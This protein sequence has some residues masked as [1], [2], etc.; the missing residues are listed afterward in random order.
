M[1][2]L[3]FTKKMLTLMFYEEMTTLEKFAIFHELPLLV[4]FLQCLNFLNIKAW[5]WNFLTITTWKL[6]FMPIFWYHFCFTTYLTFW[7]KEK[8]KLENRSAL[9]RILAVFWL[10]W[11]ENLDFLNNMQCRHGSVLHIWK[12]LNHSDFSIYAVLWSLFEICQPFV[13]NPPRTEN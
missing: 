9:L 10:F 7:S 5:S 3:V 6:R 13:K 11:G 2:N 4:C 12:G 8:F 1:N